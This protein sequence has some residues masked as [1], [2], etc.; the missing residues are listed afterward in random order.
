[1][2]PHHPLKHS[3]TLDR[4]HFSASDRIRRHGNHEGNSREISDIANSS[5]QKEQLKEGF[6]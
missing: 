6:G 3:D 1:M 4:V 5:R 2:C